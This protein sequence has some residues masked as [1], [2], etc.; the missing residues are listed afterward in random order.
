MKRSLVLLLSLALVACQDRPQ[1][2]APDAPEATLSRGANTVDVIV[3]LKSDFAPGAHASNQA[4]AAE[5]A[6]ALGVSPRFAYGTALFGFAASVPEGRLNA[7]RNDPRV[8]YVD[9]DAP[10]SI[11]APHITAKPGS[12]GGSTAEVA[13]W[14]IKRI[15]A[16]VN[17]NEGAGIHVYVIDTGIDSDHPDLTGRLGNG[18]APVSCRG[19]GCKYSWDDDNDHGTHVAGTVGAN[20]NDIDVVGVAAQVTLHAVKV[21]SSSGSGTRSGV[22]AGIDWV[23]NETKTLGV[24]TV[25]NMSLGGSGSK[26]GTCTSTGFTGTD[27]YHQSICSAKNVGVVFAVAAGND[28]ADAQG[29]VP[30]AYDDAVITVSATKCTFSNQT[31]DSG[32]DDWTSWSNWGDNSAT[33][34][35]SAVTSAPVTIAA[36]GSSVLSLKRGGGTVS[37]SGTSMA[38]PHTAGA[39]ALFLKTN[40][41]Q[42]NG[43]AFENTRKAIMTGAEITKD[44]FNNTSGNVHSENFLKV[45]SL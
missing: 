12:G 31:C 44:N 16:D 7:L 3:A 28:G 25:A 37:F 14:G 36:P 18:H 2:I 26:T 30:A 27:T 8:A 38:S 20:D 41:Q 42:A 35:G 9:F 24:A 45:G 17:T 5:I 43:T 6:Q 22:I 21:L 33:F 15:G 23:A 4:R 19:G 32:T 11:P 10:V 1:P 29:A 34:S 39:A 13:P 40:A